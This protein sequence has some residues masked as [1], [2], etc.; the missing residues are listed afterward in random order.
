MQFYNTPLDRN[1]IKNSTNFFIIGG[2]HIVQCYK[3][4]FKSGNIDEVD[5]AKAS[6]F[7][8]ILVFA[9]KA[10]HMKLLFLSHVL[11]QDMVGP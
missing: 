1:Q 5:K 9:P 7:N 3:N 10:E 4:L 2:Q 8:I 11:N 6:T